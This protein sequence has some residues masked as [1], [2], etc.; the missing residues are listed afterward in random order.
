MWSHL[1]SISHGGI[2]HSQPK[3]YCI[4]T[5]QHLFR[6]QIEC[7]SQFR[8]ICAKAS[9]EYYPG[10]SKILFNYTNLSN[11]PNRHHYRRKLNS[12]QPPDLFAHITCYLAATARYSHI[13]VQFYTHTSTYFDLFYLT[14]RP[15]AVSNRIQTV[16]LNAVPNRIQ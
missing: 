3:P 8:Q 14:V 12:S 13:Q 2:R 11:I 4:E 7:V 15:N 10:E 16:R 9:G 6:I 5:M 1:N